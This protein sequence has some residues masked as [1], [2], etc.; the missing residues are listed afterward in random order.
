MNLRS[1]FSELKVG[2]TI[3]LLMSGETFVIDKIY[4]GGYVDMTSTDF[5]KKIFTFHE[6]FYSIRLINFTIL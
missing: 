1:D 4:P 2:D 6:K 5:F 3:K